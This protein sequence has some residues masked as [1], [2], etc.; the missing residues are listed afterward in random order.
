VTARPPD[1]QALPARD[2]LAARVSALIDRLA[3]GARD[4]A[5]RDALL[6]DLLAWQRANVA[7]YGRIV[8]RLGAAEQD[9]LR[10]PAVPT[11]VFRALR[12]ASHGPHDD[13]RVFRTSGTTAAARGSHHLRD[14]SFYDRAARAAARY[15]LF[16]DVPR[17]QLVILAPA[18]HELPDSSLAYMLDRF[19]PWFGEGESVYAWH[20]GRLDAELLD[21]TLRDA[22]KQDRKIALLGTSFAFVHAEDALGARRFALTAGSRIMQ[23]GG[24]KGRAREIDPA[25]M[26]SLLA[27]RYGV[28]EPWIVQEYGMT[29]LSS[30][31]YETTLREAALGRQPGPRRLWWPGWVRV[32]IVDPETLAEVPAGAEGLA[33][34]DDL[35]NVDTACAIQTADRAGA[36]LD[37]VSVLGRA[38]AATPRGCSIAADAALGG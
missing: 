30:Q 8:E 22:Q 10:W 26:S 17:M 11:D 33:R 25:Q 36:L 2:A 32:T 19:G 35:A 5:A 23:T 14:L 6:R 4:D 7:A 28:A 16:P 20:A 15:A 37:G 1:P 24:F 9:P 29:E 13:A 27:Q 31:L 34:V 38:A 21:R 18:A 3:N 12:V